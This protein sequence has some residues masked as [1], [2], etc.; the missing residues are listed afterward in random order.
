[1][2]VREA[3]ERLEGVKEV[4]AEADAATWT[5]QVLRKDGRLPDVASIGKAIKSAGSHF[6]LRGVEVVAVGMIVEATDG[7]RLKLDKTQE[8][9]RLLPIAHKVQWSFRHQEPLPI[10]AR[11]RSAFAAVSKAARR[12]VRITGPLVGGALEVR[13]LARLGK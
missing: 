7:L 4:S 1:M 9:V 11:E 6:E 8:E 13:K 2:G 10:S 12:R 3:L 5:C